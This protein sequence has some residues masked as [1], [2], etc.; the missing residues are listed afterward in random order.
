MIEVWT[1]TRISDIVFEYTEGMSLYGCPIFQNGVD[2]LGLR[3]VAMAYARGRAGS[4]AEGF[5]GWVERLNAENNGG[6]Y[7]MIEVRPAGYIDG[8]CSD[9]TFG[10]KRC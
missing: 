6:E 10:M 4:V 9:N 5:E 2:R 7:V 3:E 1:K 8:V